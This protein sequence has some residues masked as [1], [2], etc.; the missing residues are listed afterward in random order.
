MCF[1][2]PSSL[3]TG[4]LLRTLVG[5]SEERRRRMAC[6]VA[7]RNTLHLGDPGQAVPRG[8]LDLGR[9]RG[10][11]EAEVIDGAAAQDGDV[12]QG[13]A[14]AVHEG[15]AGR[16][17][18]VAHG[19]SSGDGPGLGVDL[20]PVAAAQVAEVLVVDGEVGGELGGCDLVAVAAMADEGVY[21]AWGL[22]RLWRWRLY[23][24]RKS[25]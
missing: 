24:R 8:V 12:G 1:Q 13:G 25:V 9:E 10:L 16:A 18:V 19:V 23:V 2:L 15:A 7:L 14:D 3:Y 11:L 21:E 20:E 5:L 17:E 22:E 4:I 6:L